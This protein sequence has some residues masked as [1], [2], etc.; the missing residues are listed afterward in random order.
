MCLPDRFRDPKT[1]WMLVPGSLSLAAAI[2]LSHFARPY[3]GAH[4]SASIP[5]A[6]MSTDGLSGL[7]FG[8]SIGVN[9]PVLRRARRCPPAAPA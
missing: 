3:A 2:L 1:R 7:F 9:L 5:F 8:V 6:R 4:P